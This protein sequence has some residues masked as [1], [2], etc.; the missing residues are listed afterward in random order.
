[1]STVFLAWTGQPRSQRP[2]FWQPSCG[3]PLNGCRRGSPKCTAIGSSSA[4]CRR[5]RPRPRTRAPCRSG[6]LGRRRARLQRLLG[7]VVPG[8]ELR[9][10]SIA[11]GQ[12]ASNTSARRAQLHVGVDER[13]A[14]DAG[15]RDDGDVAHH[16]HVEQP[17][18]VQPAR[19]TAC[20]GASSGSSRK[21][22]RPEAPPALEHADA[23]ARLREPAGGDP[24]AEPG[25]H[26]DDVIA[27]PHS[28]LQV[29]D[30]AHTIIR[31]TGSA[32]GFGQL[33]TKAGVGGRGR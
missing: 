20:R 5:A 14:A 33:S 25:A 10:R 24:A 21:S 7:A 3:T 18:G 11:S 8:I 17:V 19:A 29:S 27:G 2:R 28:G 12:P 13:A 15:R 1:M 32:M 23:L 30:R 16:P 31:R 4:S 22:S 26:D 9:A 6:G